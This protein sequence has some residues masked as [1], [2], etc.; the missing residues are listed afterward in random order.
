MTTVSFLG[1]G[2]IVEINTIPAKKTIDS[3]IEI[4][5]EDEYEDLLSTG[6]KL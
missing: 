5:S 6:Q 4:L 1:I 3:F 2:G